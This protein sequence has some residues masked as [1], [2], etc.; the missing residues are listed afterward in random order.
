MKYLNRSPHTVKV[1]N[2]TSEKLS[3]PR[4]AKESWWLNGREKGQ[5][6][7]Q[8]AHH[9]GDREWTVHARWL[10]RL[11]TRPVVLAVGKTGRGLGGDCSVLPTCL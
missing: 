4:G 11:G 1:I 10:T 8:E 7:S 5:G 6:G 3:Q 2:D 9:R